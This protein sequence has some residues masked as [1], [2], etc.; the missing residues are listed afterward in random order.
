MYTFSE[1]N[2]EEPLAKTGRTVSISSEIFNSLR[3]HF[4]VMQA[5]QDT[6]LNF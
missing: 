6:K 5:E 4:W 1:P 3:E 2:Y